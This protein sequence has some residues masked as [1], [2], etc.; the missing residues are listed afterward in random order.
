MQ[1]HKDKEK[2]LIIDFGSQVTKLI[3]RNIRELGVYS[4]IITPE[5]LKKIKNF[6]TI[7]GIIFSGGP[8]SVNEK[9]FQTVSKEIFGK[10][11]PILGICYG[12]QLIAKLFGGTIKPSK[13]RR[14]FGRAYLIKKNSSLLTKNYLKTKRLVWM[15][16]EDAVI[17]LPLGFKIIASTKDSK[18]TIIEN[19]KKKFLEFSFILKLPIQIMENKYLK[20]SFF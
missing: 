16:H 12:L 5:E 14:E 13:K 7:R 9:K 10:K 17:K 4:E 1:F 2:V 11:I 20:I 18:L 6:N 3:G 8:S 19:F 15:S